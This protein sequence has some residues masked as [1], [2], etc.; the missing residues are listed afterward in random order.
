M[1]R[2]YCFQE[3][4]VGLAHGRGL[5]EKAKGHQREDHVVTGHDGPFFGPND[6]GDAGHVPDDNIIIG[7]GA[8]FCGPLGQA[9]VDLVTGGIHAGGV[10]FIFRVLRHPELVVEEAGFFADDGTRGH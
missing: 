3:I 7:D 8:V 9:V 5:R 6:M 10:F 2:G 1:S 4:G